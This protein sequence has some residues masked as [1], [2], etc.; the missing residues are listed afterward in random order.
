MS[1]RSFCG[2]NILVDTDDGSAPEKHD[3]GWRLNGLEVINPFLDSA[4]A[5]LT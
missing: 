1:G 4:S 3:H 2:T 5:D